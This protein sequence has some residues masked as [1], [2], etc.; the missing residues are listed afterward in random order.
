VYTVSITDL[1][2]S[3]ISDDIK[4]DYYAFWIGDKNT[5]AFHRDGAT[6]FDLFVSRRDEDGVWGTP[7][8]LIPKVQL[9]TQWSTQS[10]L[11]SYVS[12]GNLFTTDHEHRNIRKVV[13]AEDGYINGAVWSTDGET[14]YFARVDDAG[15]AGFWSVPAQGGKTTQ[16]MTMGDQQMGIGTVAV[17]LDNLYFTSKDV[18]AD[19]WVLQLSN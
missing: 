13:G 8:M 12:D 3:L 11:L 16:F 1:S 14:I 17:D 6:N 9:A 15:I 18:D 10:K 5:V 19:I 2:E 7:E 4:H